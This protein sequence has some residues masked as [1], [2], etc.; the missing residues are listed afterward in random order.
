MCVFVPRGVERQAPF[1][2]GVCVLCTC[3]C[4]VQTPVDGRPIV[5]REAYVPIDG[6]SVSVIPGFQ[7]FAKETSG[8][9][10]SVRSVRFDS[11]APKS[12]LFQRQKWSVALFLCGSVLGFPTETIVGNLAATTS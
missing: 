3:M 7:G 6:Q 5:N 4:V 9:R 1:A 12:L 8:L 2:S 11:N 10:G